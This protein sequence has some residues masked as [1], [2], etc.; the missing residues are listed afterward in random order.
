[1]DFAVQEA[2]VA[3]YWNYRDFNNLDFYG[4]NSADPDIFDT[5]GAN[6]APTLRTTLSGLASA[7]YDVS[8]VQL[9]TTSGTQAGLFANFDPSGS[10]WNATTL[11]QR[12]ASTFRTGITVPGWEVDLQPLGQVSGPT[13]N[14]LVGDAGVGVARGA[15]LGLAYRLTPTS[16]A[17]IRYPTSQPGRI[18]RQYTTFSVSALG[19]PA[20]KYQWRK[21]GAN[22][23][24]AT[25]ATYTIASPLASDAGIYSVVVSNNLNVVAVVSSNAFLNVFT[26]TGPTTIDITVGTNAPF[27]FIVA[28]G[29]NSDGAPGNTVAITNATAFFSAPTGIVGLW[30]YRDFAGLDMFGVG[31][32]AAV[33]LLESV[34]TRFAPDLRTTVS[35]L[36]AGNYEVYLVQHRATDG[37][38]VPGL[39]ADIEAGG[40]AV[41]TNLRLSDT[42]SV[43]TGK[44]TV[45]TWEVILSPL[46]Q[47]NGTGFNVLV[48]SAQGV[49]RGDYIGVAYRVAAASTPL[50]I[51]GNPSSRWRMREAILRSRWARL[52]RR[53]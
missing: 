33:D 34:P 47:I 20:P 14:V 11:R 39:L 45:I 16:P 10:N 19:N 51:V 31:T 50:T 36:P 8:L 18:R 15:Y 25:N 6:A 7:I 9:S 48:G 26:P 3:G 29:F 2:V 49:A 37:V 35:G 32:P 30:H 38:T 13:I 21:N 43:R 46:G 28:D 22:I 24:N 4:V 12:N 41:P 42:N 5:S 53:R 40:L 52:G 27:H 23:L 1:M 44:I 17:S